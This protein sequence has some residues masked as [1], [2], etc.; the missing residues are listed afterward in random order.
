MDFAAIATHEFDLRGEGLLWV[1][2]VVPGGRV[3]EV[4]FARPG[5]GIA[6]IRI[7]RRVRVVLHGPYVTGEGE[8]RAESSRVEKREAVVEFEWVYGSFSFL[9]FTRLVQ[10]GCGLEKRLERRRIG[11]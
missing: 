2:G 5:R 10:L 9:F 4:N 3:V 8:E 11:V 7:R 6:G 1:L